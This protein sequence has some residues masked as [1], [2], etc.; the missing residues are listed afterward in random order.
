MNDNDEPG[1]APVL[2][3]IR[4]SREVEEFCWNS[5]NPWAAFD[6]ADESSPT[7]LTLRLNIWTVPLSLDTAN[8]WTFGERAILYI[9]ALFPPLRTYMQ[10]VNENKQAL[11]IRKTIKIE[12]W[13]LHAYQNL[14]RLKRCWWRRINPVTN[15]KTVYIIDQI[16][17]VSEVI[18]LFWDMLKSD[19]TFLVSWPWLC[20]RH[21]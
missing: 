17:W 3:E 21:G 19:Y 14:C 18:S 9:S 7:T 2:G 1:L 16:W 6:W 8:H 11:A 10:A 4:A 12:H 15:A 20:W 5:A 13:I